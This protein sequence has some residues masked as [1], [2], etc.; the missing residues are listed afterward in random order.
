MR[1]N[2]TDLRFLRDSFINKKQAGRFKKLMVVYK[3]TPLPQSFGSSDK[4]EA[5]MGMN[6]IDWNYKCRTVFVREG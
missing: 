3:K 5:Q 1:Y 4:A 2:S 6:E